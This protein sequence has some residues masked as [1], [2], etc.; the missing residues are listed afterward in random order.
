MENRESPWG[1]TLSEPVVVALHGFLSS[2][3][4]E[5]LSKNVRNIF[6]NHVYTEMDVPSLDM[7]ECVLQLQALFDLL[8]IL[9]KVPEQQAKDSS[10][11]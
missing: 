3:S 7:E 10:F 11:P 8:D 1:N 2:V 5:R 6:L 9:E 4:V